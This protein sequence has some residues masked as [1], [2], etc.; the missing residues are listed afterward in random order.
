MKTGI[1]WFRNDLR[2]ADN[3]SLYKAASENDKVIA[4]FFFDPRLFDF[5]QFGFKKVEKYR[6]KFLVESVTE[7][8]E[9]LS[10]LNITLL[11]YQNKP[12]EIFSKLIEDY[13]IRKVYLQKEWTTEEKEIFDSIKNEIKNPNIEWMES[14]DQ[15]LF[16]PDDIPF[17]IE[18]VPKVFTNFR[19]ECE[20]FATVR[21]EVVI[22][23]LAPENMLE[24]TTDIPKVSDLDFQ[25]F[26]IDSRTAFPFKGGEDQ[27]NQRVQGY[28]WNTK[29][30][31]YY[32]KTRNGLVGT[33]YSSKLSAWLSN[34]SISARTIYHQV[35]NYENDVQKN[36]STYWL[37][38]ELIWRDFFKYISL[39]HGNDLFKI[40]GILHKDYSWSKDIQSIRQWINGETKESFINA[41]M[42]ELKNTGWM[43]NRGR[44]NVA[45]YFAK[46]LKLDWRVGAAYF[47]SLL[48]DYDVHSNYGNWQYVAGVGNDPRDRKFNIEFQSQRYDPEQKFQSLWLQ[49]TLF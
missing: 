40:K 25:E 38:F 11:V 47:E 45:S 4:V 44:Q 12:E 41:N 6:T 8:K 46:E 31:S 39:K 34:G 37:I 49:Q 32:K 48:I 42:I 33:D 22:E 21:A 5:D 9:N 19:K 29:K 43:S 30:L 20:K 7:L 3:N 24:N 17:D 36:Q 10:K 16:H 14:Y 2:I 26:E 1:V 35:R 27:A 23:P 15:F 28:F 13:K 18:N